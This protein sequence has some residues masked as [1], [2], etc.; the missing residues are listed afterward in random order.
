[1]GQLPPS[2]TSTNAP[3]YRFQYELAFQVSP[4]ILQGGIASNYQGG[5]LPITFLTGGVPTNLDNAF[6][7]YLPL[8]GSTLIS[9]SVGMYPFANQQVAGNATIQQPLTL[10]MLMIAPVNQPGGYLTKLATFSSLQQSL[11]QHNA[12]GGT[13]NVATPAMVYQ[14]LLMTTMTDAS[15]EISAEDNKQVQILWQI[16]FIQPLLTAAGAAAALTGLLQKLQTGAQIIGTP[17]YSGNTSSSPANLVSVTGALGNVQN[18]LAAFGG[19][20]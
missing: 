19:G 10:S 8:P 3:Y 1:M 17:S 18:A 2:L 15:P 6:A 12:A 11:A 7:T 4:I 13:Y 9:Q 5:M 16:D 20:L 14:N